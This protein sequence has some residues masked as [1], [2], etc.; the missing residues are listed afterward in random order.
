MR[1]HRIAIAV[2]LA[3]A[4][5]SLASCAAADTEESATGEIGADAAFPV[6]I[7]VP[8]ADDPLVVESEPERIVALSPDAAIALHEL[9]VTDRLVAVPEA[10]LNPTLNGHADEMADVPNAVS[11]ETSPEPEQVLAWDPDLIV[12]TAR[13]TGE[14]DAARQLG[15][16]GVPV[17]TLA[18]GWSSSD[19]IVENLDLIGQATGRDEAAAELGEEIR[20]GIADVRAHGEETEGEPTVAVLSNQ[21]GPVFLNAGASLTTELLGS[22]GAVSAAESIGVTKTM[23]IQP[24]QLVAADPDAI[25]LVDVTGRGEESF[26]QLLGNPAVAGLDAVV[27]DR[28]R[29]FPAR[30][31]YGLGG[32]E[33]VSGSE[34]VL[35]WIQSDIAG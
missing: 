16:T 21:A 24:E 1:T 29:M 10:A 35:E 14:Q 19:A 5:A 26:D 6:T 20:D 23:P 17:L 31:V 2:V 25:M 27:E 32:R 9:G 30:E 3:V 34:A 7:D 11:G 13:H 15:T 33:V 18:N 28:V 8:G 4:G 22:A 12:V